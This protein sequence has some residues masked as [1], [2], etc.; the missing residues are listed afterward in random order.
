MEPK[1]IA[2]RL[3]TARGERSTA[4]IAAA[5]GTSRS[6][7]QMYE[8]GQRIPKDSIKIKL[9]AYFGISVQELFF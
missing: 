6:A 9:A 3:K 4:E 7:I 1:I 5:V 8:A 2:E